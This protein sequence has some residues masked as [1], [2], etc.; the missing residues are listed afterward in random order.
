M[1][2]PSQHFSTDKMKL[3]EH[4]FIQMHMH[5]L[6][7]CVIREEILS[8]LSLQDDLESFVT[9]LGSTTSLFPLT[10]PL[11]HGSSTF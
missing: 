8:T 11:S 3:N 5:A 7:I 2:A 10:M 6:C 1:H 4:L 9:L